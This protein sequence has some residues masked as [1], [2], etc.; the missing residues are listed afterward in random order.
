MVILKL[1]KASNLIMAASSKK[2][3]QNQKLWLGLAWFWGSML[4]FV[5]GGALTALLYRRLGWWPPSEK[6]LAHH[7]THPASNSK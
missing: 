6:F 5:V 1:T 2:V 7:Y 4:G 3:N